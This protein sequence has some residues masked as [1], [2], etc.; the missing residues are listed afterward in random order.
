MPVS[1]LLAAALIAIFSFSVAVAEEQ[2]GPTESSSIL[3]MPESSTKASS[4]PSSDI[5]TL[6][7]E[8]NSN[9]DSTCYTM[10]TYML[11]KDAPGSD[12]VHPVGYTSC[13]PAFR[14]EMKVT[15]KPAEPALTW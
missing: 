11:K 2:K 15:R 12:S 3:V 7:R 10:R 4:G 1:R 9:F 5:S 6:L 8:K 13:Q 14:Y